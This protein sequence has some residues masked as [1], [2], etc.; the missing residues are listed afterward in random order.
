[1]DPSTKHF[2][3]QATFRVSDDVVTQEMGEKLVLVHLQTDSIQVL[4]RT[5]AQLW[6][7]LAQSLNKA[8]IRRRLLD[9]FEIGEQ[10]LEVEMDRILFELESAQ[11][12]MARHGG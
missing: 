4:N 12:I 11:L 6:G 7:L 9:Q 5:G 10:Q 3:E 2:S 1:M 8:E